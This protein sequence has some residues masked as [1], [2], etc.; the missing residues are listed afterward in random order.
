MIT[1]R[2]LPIVLVAAALATPAGAQSQVAVTDRTVDVD[3]ARLMT[4]VRVLSADSMEGRA[5]GSRGSAKARAYLLRRFHEV[6]L[7]PIDDSFAWPFTGRG[8]RGG[9]D[10]SGV[11]LVAVIAGTTEPERYIVVTAH[12]DHLGIRDGAVFNGADDNASGTAALLEIAQELTETPPEHS[13]IIAALDAEES[14]MRGAH[15][16]IDDPPVPRSRILAN[17]NLDMV[18]R[19]D[20][21]ELWVAGTYHYPNLLPLVEEIAARAPVELRIGHDRPRGTGQDDWT[22]MSD[23]AAFHAAGIPFLY[24]GVEDH[25]DYHKPTDDAERIDPA[26]YGDAVETII[27]LLRELDAFFLD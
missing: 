10:E 25:P 15:A 22:T 9:S 7:Q 14:G 21:G 8:A 11:N 2:A 16:F 27:D 23:H 18:S 3:T 13:I 5:A 1:T 26:F 17:L 4:D 12:Y 20:T 19:S 24:A 6:G